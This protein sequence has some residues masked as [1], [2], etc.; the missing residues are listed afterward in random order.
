MQY[1]YGNVKYIY[2]SLIYDLFKDD[3]LAQ[4]I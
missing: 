2:I 3:L 4:T 1:A